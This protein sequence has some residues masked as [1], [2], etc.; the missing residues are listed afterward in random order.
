M[1]SQRFYIRQQMAWTQRGA[2]LLLQVCAQA[3]NDD[4]RTTFRRWYPE[5]QT[6]VHQEQEA[7]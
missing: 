5:M 6:G 2:H 1:V 4:L 7:A 3:L